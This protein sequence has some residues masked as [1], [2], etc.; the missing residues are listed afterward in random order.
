MR[1]KRKAN[2]RPT[3]T[4]DFETVKLL[5]C[6]KCRRVSFGGPCLYCGKRPE[7]KVMAVVRGGRM[8]LTGEGGKA[9]G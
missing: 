5:W 9:V 4:P 3:R 2:L 6:K 8:A 7:E 1:V